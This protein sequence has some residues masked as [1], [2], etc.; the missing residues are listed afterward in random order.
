MVTLKCIDEEMINY[1]GLKLMGD[2]SKWWGP[3]KA[4]LKD[5]LCVGDA[6]WVFGIS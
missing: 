3:T 5:E 2:T 6:I 1:G 4:N